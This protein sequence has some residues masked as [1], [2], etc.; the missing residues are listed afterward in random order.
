MLNGSYSTL[1]RGIA[2]NFCDEHVSLHS[3]AVAQ[4]DVFVGGPARDAGRDGQVP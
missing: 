3:A 4:V 2:I 1:F